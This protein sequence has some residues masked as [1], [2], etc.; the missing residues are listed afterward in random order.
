MRQLT[1]LDTQF[2]ALENAGQSGHVAG[3]AILDLST[4]PGGGAGVATVSK[5]AEGSYGMHV[6]VIGLLGVQVL[7]P[8]ASLAGRNGGRNVA[9]A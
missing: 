6:R 5:H 1:S 8:S 2:L 7:P 4:A 3:L 9:P